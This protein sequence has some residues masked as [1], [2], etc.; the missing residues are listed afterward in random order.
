MPS[1]S[2]APSAQATPAHPYSA[3][4]QAGRA[5]DRRAAR[6]VSEQIQRGRR[7]T[8]ADVVRRFRDHAVEWADTRGGLGA[9]STRP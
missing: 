5:A 3:V 2:S 7:T 6:V 8:P 9:A 1:T 4:G